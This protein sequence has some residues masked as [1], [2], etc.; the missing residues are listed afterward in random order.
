MPMH[1]CVAIHP[2]NT[3]VHRQIYTD[4]RCGVIIA[5]EWVIFGGKR[6]PS[7][8]QA[9]KIQLRREQQNGS[10]SRCSRR[11]TSH[12]S[13]SHQTFAASTEKKCPAY[14]PESSAVDFADAS[15]FV[16][17]AI[18]SRGVP[19]L[20]TGN[21]RGWMETLPTTVPMPMTTIAIMKVPYGRHS[22]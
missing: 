8:C 19:S 7:R 1:S 5:G 15:A 4:I 14:R 16:P 12:K 9:S 10:T 18:W 3:I 13:Q 11:A 20:P 21:N 22:P 2:L 6:L 17:M